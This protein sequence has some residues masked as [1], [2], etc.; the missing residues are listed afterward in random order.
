MKQKAVLLI[1]LSLPSLAR[2]SGHGPV[3]GLA[4]PTNSQ[5][6][7]SFDAGVFGRSADIGSQASFRG[8]IGYGFTPHFTLSF[9]APAVVGDTPLPPTRIQPGSDFDLTAAWRFQHR[10]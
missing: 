10:A 2:A 6:Q 8:L 5:G 3:F 7:W 4:T 1:L 9:T